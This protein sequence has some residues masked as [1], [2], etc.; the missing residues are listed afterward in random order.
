M[1]LLVKNLDE[2]MK[3][4]Y[5]LDEKYIMINVLEFLFDEFVWEIFFEGVWFIRDKVL[6]VNEKFI[7]EGVY[8]RFSFWYFLMFMVMMVIVRGEIFVVVFFFGILWRCMNCF[9]FIVYFWV[10][11]GEMFDYLCFGFKEN[12]IKEEWFGWDM[13]VGMM[14]MILFEIWMSVVVVNF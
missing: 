10:E 1:E 9:L 7:L 4:W 2:I 13:I 11:F 5:G 6:K 14:E 3:K 8:L 12:L